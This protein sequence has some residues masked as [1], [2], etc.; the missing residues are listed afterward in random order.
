MKP[1]AF[2]YREDDAREI[3]RRVM[4][5]QAGQPALDTA[6]NQTVR[7]RWYYCILTEDLDAADDA[8]TGYKQAQVRILRYVQPV[9]PATLNMEQSTTSNGLETVTNRFTTFSAKTGDVLLI[10]WTGSEFSPVTVSNSGAHKHAR[11]TSCLGNGYYTAHLSLNPVFRIPDPE[12]GTGTLE[13]VGT[14]S[15]MFNECSPCSLLYGENLP[16]VGTEPNTDDAVC[17]I[18][19][20]PTRTSVDGDGAEV[21][22]YDPRKLT[23]PINAHVLIADFGDRVEDP[24]PE[25]GTGTGTGTATPTVTLW[26]VL[27]GGYDLIG[28]PDRFY[29]C[30]TVDDVKYVKLV[31]CDT[32]ITEGHYCPGHQT[33]CPASV[34]TGSV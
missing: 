29:E 15:A 18:L 26:M 9:D 3:H 30:C 2:S 31:R 8:E 34:G 19:S 6:R 16:P 33:E 5:I 21:Y 14:G 4:G 24:S 27:S 1:S 11:I 20:Q 22:V 13:G 25:V 28:I 23:L 32:Y 17:G 10:V 7:N 12:T